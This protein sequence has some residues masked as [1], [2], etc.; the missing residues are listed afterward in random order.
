MNSEEREM[1]AN[2]LDL[3]VA[4]TGMIFDLR[5][6][7]KALRALLQEIHPDFEKQ[8][9]KQSADA[10]ES[11]GETY[12]KALAKSREAAAARDTLRTAGK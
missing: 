5:R 3:T 6:E 10:D 7:I 4:N 12:G 11:G 1:L 2:S 9:R 8:Y